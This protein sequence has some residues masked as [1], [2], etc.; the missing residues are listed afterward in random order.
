MSSTFMQY[1]SYQETGMRID[2]KV[3]SIASLCTELSSVLC[4]E[5]V[6]RRVQPVS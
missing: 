5:D 4:S 6:W 2:D 3:A 1:T